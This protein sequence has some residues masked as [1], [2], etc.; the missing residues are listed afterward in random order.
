M[1]QIVY[2]VPAHHGPHALFSG[3]EYLRLLAARLSGFDALAQSLLGSRSAFIQSDLDSM[4]QWVGQQSSHCNE[5]KRVEEALASL[6]APVSSQMSNFLSAAEAERAKDLLLRTAE[7]KNTVRQ[8]NR[9]YEGVV[10]KESH[11]NAV[12][13]NLYATALVY[14]D[15]RL[16]SHESYGRTEE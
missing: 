3:A 13:R 14:A 1:E 5:I 6:V 9:V 4:M 10:R 15:P 11:H 2:S 7:I 16:G 12:L 8:I